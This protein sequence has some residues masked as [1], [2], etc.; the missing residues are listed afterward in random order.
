MTVWS[1]CVEVPVASSSGSSAGG[2]AGAKV[3]KCSQLDFEEKQMVVKI[4]E[5]PSEVKNITLREFNWNLVCGSFKAQGD[6]RLVATLYINGVKVKTSL[7][8]TG[9]NRYLK[10]KL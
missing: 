9:L 10:L 7:E 6:S 4:A 2:G 3:V 5:Y 8:E 1:Y